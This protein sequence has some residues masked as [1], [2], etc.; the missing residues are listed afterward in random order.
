MRMKQLAE[1]HALREDLARNAESTIRDWTPE[2][3]AQNV[4]ALT[5]VILKRNDAYA[6][7]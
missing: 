2:L 3:F 4:L 1:D 7:G 5:N 6:G